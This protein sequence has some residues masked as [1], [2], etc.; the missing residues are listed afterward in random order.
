[1]LLS[2]AA[3]IRC[4]LLRRGTTALLPH[5]RSAPSVL[6]RYIHPVQS[7]NESQR[8]V[9][10]KVQAQITEKQ[11][12]TCQ[13]ETHETAGKE[14]LLNNNN[15]QHLRD[16]LHPSQRLKQ[17]RKLAIDKVKAEIAAQEIDT[18]AM[19]VG[20]TNAHSD[21]HLRRTLK[22]PRVLIEKDPESPECIKEIGVVTT[23]H[24]KSRLKLAKEKAR[25]RII[26]FEPQKRP[27]KPVFVSTITTAE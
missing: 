27:M 26:T 24:M 16:S 25:S 17:A 10:E 2:P 13:T 9:L 6:C 15:A 8:I 11:Q 23:Q 22:Q 4:A 19:A 18:K 7:L 14:G 1:M 3:T 12:S 5:R 20:E 21:Y